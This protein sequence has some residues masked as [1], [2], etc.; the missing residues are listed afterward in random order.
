VGRDQRD[1][2]AAIKDHMVQPDDFERRLLY[3]YNHPEETATEDVEVLLP[4]RRT[5]ERYS[6]PVYTDD[7]AMLGRIEVYS[8]VTEVRALQR[9]KDEFLSL[10]SHELKTPVTSI[11]GYAQL[12]QR[13][14][15]R[16]A[17]RKARSL[18]TP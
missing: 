7:G 17:A 11:R 5:L 14:A 4:S 12:L 15:V 3:L 2:V 13:R 1:V 6:S 18:H 16:D 10:V 9:N 8:D